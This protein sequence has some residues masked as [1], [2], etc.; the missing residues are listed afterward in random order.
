MP[1]RTIVIGASAGGVETLREAVGAANSE[2]VVA[3]VCQPKPNTAPERRHRATG[4]PPVSVGQSPPLQSPIC[5]RAASML[6][7]R[8]RSGVHQY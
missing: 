1:R 3:H 7:A 6:P 5:H 4:R 2:P 8:M